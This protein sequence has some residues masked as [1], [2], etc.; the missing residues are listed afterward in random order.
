MYL[1][2][3][4]NYVPNAWNY[5]HGCGHCHR[6]LLDWSQLNVSVSAAAAS[7][8]PCDGG[9]CASRGGEKKREVLRCRNQLPGFP[10]GRI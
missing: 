4:G 1:N 10:Q 8:S 5:E 6:D 2:Y 7:G 9:T 3:L